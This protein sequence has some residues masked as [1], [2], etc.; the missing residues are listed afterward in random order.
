MKVY[1]LI[2]TDNDGIQEIDV[3]GNESEARAEANLR[4]ADKWK[5]GYSGYGG[6][7]WH[8]EEREVL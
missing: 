7:G 2:E 3:F 4:E 5:K 6:L 1:L 8:V